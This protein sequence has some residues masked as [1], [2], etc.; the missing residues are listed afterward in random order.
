MRTA[1][2]TGAS[3]GIGSA[4]ARRLASDGLTV[5]A[6]YH[7]AADRAERLVADLPGTGHSRHEDLGARAPTRLPGS[8]ITSRPLRIAS[9]CSSTALA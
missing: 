4:I 3:G 7:S 6:G 9:T 5:I 1:V 2:V 8:R